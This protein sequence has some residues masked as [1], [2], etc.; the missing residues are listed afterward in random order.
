[1]TLTKTIELHL[2]LSRQMAGVNGL[3]HSTLESVPKYS[4]P[5]SFYTVENGF[6]LRIN[7]N[8]IVTPRIEIELWDGQGFPPLIQYDAL[9]LFKLPDIMISSYNLLYLD[10]LQH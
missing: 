9:L 8:W 3:A 4:P 5:L 2:Q 1:M 10:Q 7:L 6:E